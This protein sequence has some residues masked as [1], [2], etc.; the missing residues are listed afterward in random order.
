MS[1]CFF[2]GES[3]G[4]GSKGTVPRSARSV[5]RLLLGAGGRRRRAVISLETAVGRLH[6]AVTGLG[7]A[8]SRLGEGVFKASDRG[9]EHPSRRRKVRRR[10]AIAIM[11]R[12][13]QAEE[14]GSIHTSLCRTLP[15]G[16]VS[17]SIPPRREVYPSYNSPV[18]R[19]KCGFIQRRLHVAPTGIMEIR[20]VRR[21]LVYPMY[22]RRSRAVVMRTG[23]P[24]PLLT[25]DP[26]SPSVITVIVCRGDFLRLPFCHRSGS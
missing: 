24:A 14:G 9:A 25:R 23:A 26:T 16:R 20:C 21:A 6:D 15:V 13:A 10:R 1:P 8:V 18:R 17:Y 12:R 2:C 22:Q 5:V 11:G 4:A 3:G 7:R 19:L